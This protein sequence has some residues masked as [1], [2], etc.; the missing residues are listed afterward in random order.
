MIKIT[1]NFNKKKYISSFKI[2]ELKNNNYIIN[3]IYNENKHD[4]YRKNVC[5][6]L[7]NNNINIQ[8]YYNL[9]KNDILYQIKYTRSL[10]NKNMLKYDL[11]QLDHQIKYLKYLRK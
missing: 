9:I 1:N 6:K 5:T 8:E 10:K 11:I 4:I 3:K 7:I 2:L